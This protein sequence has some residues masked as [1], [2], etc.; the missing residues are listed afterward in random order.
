M[1]HYSFLT[2]PL[3]MEWITSWIEDTDHSGMF[4]EQDES[5]RYRRARKAIKEVDRIV[6]DCVNAW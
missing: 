2:M 3:L 5:Y 6:Y 1:L 4:T